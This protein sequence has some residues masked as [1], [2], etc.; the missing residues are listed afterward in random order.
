MPS[1][2]LQY[3]SY[4]FLY[5]KPSIDV[6]ISCYFK[7]S[8]E[9]Y[10]KYLMK[11]EREKKLST[12]YSSFHRIRKILYLKNDLWFSPYILFCI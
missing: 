7:Q 3:L 10:Y 4:I 8:L 11:C 1:E 2:T 9:K 12:Y 6:F 5:E